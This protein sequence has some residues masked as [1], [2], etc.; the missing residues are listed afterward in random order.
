MLKLLSFKMADADG[1]N[2]VLAKTRLAKGAQ[3]FVSNGD[4]VIP[5]EDGTLPNDL[6]KA[7][8]LNEIL[9]D[10]LMELEAYKQSLATAELL[11]ETAPN[12][13]QADQ[14]QADIRAHKYSI[15]TC[16]ANMETLAARIFELRGG[17]AKVD[18]NAKG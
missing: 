8:M 5:T 2:A 15:K 7:N 12:K 17:M 4:I 16:E 14:Y 18:E 13:N 3:V 9:S 10:K 11:L 6:Q 1:M